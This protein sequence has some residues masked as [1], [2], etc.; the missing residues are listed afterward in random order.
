VLLVKV[1]IRLAQRIEPEARRRAFSSSSTGGHK[2]RKKSN[3]D[4]CVG[5]RLISD[6]RGA[7]IFPGQCPLSS[8]EDAMFQYL[9]KLCRSSQ[10]SDRAPLHAPPAL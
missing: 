7:L 8:Q 9:K 10:I 2:V 1:F 3:R 6:R 4:F 5:I